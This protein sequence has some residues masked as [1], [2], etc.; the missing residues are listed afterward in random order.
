LTSGQEEEK[1]VQGQI[2]CSAVDALRCSIVFGSLID[3][4]FEYLNCRICEIRTPARH[5]IAEGG[6]TGK[7]L[8]H[9]A[10]IGF[11][12]HNGG[13]VKSTAKNL[14]N[15]LNLEA[16]ISAMAAVTAIVEKERNNLIPK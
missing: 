6:R 8:Y 5:S 7:F 14:C 16:A 4:C 2:G 13:A 12:R 1:T 11:A 10:G 9:D 3:P 15:G